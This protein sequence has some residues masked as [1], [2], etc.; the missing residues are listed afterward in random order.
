MMID[1]HLFF[2]KNL[3]VV[4]PSICSPCC[5]PSLV[6]VVSAVSALVV[7]VVVVES[8]TATV[9]CMAL[10]GLSSHQSSF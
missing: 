1:D 5:Y 2:K 7:V 9:T 6:V 8:C 4:T 3:R 10:H